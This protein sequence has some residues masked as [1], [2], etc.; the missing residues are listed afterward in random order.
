LLAFIIT[1]VKLLIALCI[2]AVIH[3]FG[4]FLLAKLFKTQVNEFSIGFGPKIVQK[5]RK[6]T[7]YSLR[8]LPLGGYVAIEGEG[9]VS[10]NPNSFN[11]K[12]TL[13]KIVILLAGATFNAILAVI[14]FLAISMSYQTGTTEI[15]EFTKGSVLSTLGLKPSDVITKINGEKVSIAED[16][17]NQKYTENQ[18]TEIE[19][20]RNSKTYTV[21]TKD[22][23][24]DIGY[25]GVMFKTVDNVVTNQ[26]DMLDSGKAATNVD[27]KEG[28]KIVEIDGTKTTNA[29]NIVSIV[30]NSAGKEITLTIDRN[31]QSITKK[32][33]PDTKKLFDLGIYSTKSVDTTLDL[34]WK[35]S[36]NN[37]ATIVGSYIDLFKG[38]VKVTDMSGIVG[39][40]QVVSKTSGFVEYLNL[41]GIL[42]LAIGV[43]N[44]MPFPPLDGGKI[45]IVLCEGI[46]RKK[47]PLKAEAVISYIG[48][49]LLIILA[50]FVT[51]ND[52]LRIF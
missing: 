16:L 18:V 27:I 41:L 39:I 4:H 3:E 6:D 40:G 48:F 35:K 17:L 46:I 45:V 21:T 1:I 50:I 8:W 13:Q 47:L 51:Y 28:D 23:V 12:N 32:L 30:R 34:A 33:T 2:V 24:K 37:V 36:Y 49:G 25:M 31:G 10:D 22:A 43:A 42:S 14:I 11:K 29:E 38:K 20:V 5:K 7:M 26:V 19:Y 9:E 44:I 15:T 52:I